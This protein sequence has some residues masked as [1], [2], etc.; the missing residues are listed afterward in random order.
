M[1]RLSFSVCANTNAAIITFAVFRSRVINRRTYG[2]DATLGKKSK[3]EE[4]ER[5]FETRSRFTNDFTR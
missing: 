2:D 1:P 5:T 3:T 4:E